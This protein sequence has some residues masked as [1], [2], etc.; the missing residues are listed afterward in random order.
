M[1]NEYKLNE[2]SNVEKDMTIK[3][4]ISYKHFE[5]A[6]HIENKSIFYALYFNYKKYVGKL[7]PIDKD[8]YYTLQGFH[9]KNTLIEKVETQFLVNS[10]KIEPCN[11]AMCLT[12]YSF[13]NEC[14]KLHYDLQKDL[15]FGKLHSFQ[16]KPIAYYSDKNLTCNEI[17]LNEFSKH[18]SGNTM[19]DYYNYVLDKIH[20]TDINIKHNMNFDKCIFGAFLENILYLYIPNES[21]KTSAKGLYLQINFDDENVNLSEVKEVQFTNFEC[22]VIEDDVRIKY[23][24]NLVNNIIEKRKLNYSFFNY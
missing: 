5:K 2:L 18:D 9:L 11:E 6:N 13:F 24:Q 22:F 23:I 4:F 14:C 1:E 21:F 10:F 12:V 19:G 3:T 8:G 20:A 16:L 15:T 17:I 7:S